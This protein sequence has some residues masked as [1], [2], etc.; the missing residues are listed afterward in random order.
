MNFEDLPE[1]LIQA[2]LDKLPV[3][4]M[5]RCTS[6]NRRF[7]RIPHPLV[8]PVAPGDD[9]MAACKKGSTLVL[10]RGTHILKTQL[11]IPINVSLSGMGIDATILRN[12]DDDNYAIYADND[13]SIS[14]ITLASKRGVFSQSINLSVSRCKFL[15]RAAVNAFNCRV[16]LMDNELRDS[17][18]SLRWWM[19][20]L[21]VIARGNITCYP[22]NITLEKC[23]IENSILWKI[24]NDIKVRRPR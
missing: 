11:R 16:C 19:K 18:V 21:P 7:H 4:D 15:S 6:L 24:S 13:L 22:I 10:L 20:M 9:L 3:P 12:E 23:A 5:I 17:I 2:C 14:D 1:E 8:I